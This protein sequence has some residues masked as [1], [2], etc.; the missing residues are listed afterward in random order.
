MRIKISHHTRYRFDSEVFLEPHYLRFHPKKTA[1]SQTESYDL[2]VSPKMAGD[3]ELLD[4]E[5]NRINFC[6]F[7]GLT[8]QL[9]IQLE[10]IVAIKE[11]NPFNF[12]IT[13]FE[14][15]RI[16]FTYNNND[17]MLLQASM[18][19]QPLG[20]ELMKYAQNILEDAD[21]QS[22]PFLTN[23]T[24]QIHNDFDVVYREEG[25]PMPAEECFSGK[26]GSCRDLSWMQISVLRQL[27]VASRFVSG[28]YYFEMEEPSYELHAWLEVFLPGAGWVGLDPSHGILTGKTHIPVAASAFPE[29]TMPVTGSIRGS[30]KMELETSLVIKT[31]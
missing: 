16:P 2:V 15:N 13:P 3:K 23:L 24:D 1:Y 22:I 5:N 12:I 11:Y 7:E 25:A 6:W 26:S 21:H 19:K 30:A 8:N 4:A 27:G 9:T 14:Y 20:E 29:N 18:A 28:Y 31:L 10:T 17:A